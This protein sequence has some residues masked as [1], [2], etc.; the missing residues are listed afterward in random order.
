MQSP[1]SDY[2]QA[3]P[4]QKEM[5][6]SIMTVIM[7]RLIKLFTPAIT[8]FVHVLHVFFFVFLCQSTLFNTVHSY[9]NVLI[10]NKN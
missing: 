9:Y 3:L 5:L 1:V 2:L 7:L 4:P 6:V 10:F 8:I